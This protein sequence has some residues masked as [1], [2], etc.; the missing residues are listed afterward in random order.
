MAGRIRR[1]QVKRMDVSI[2]IEGLGKLNALIQALGPSNRRRLNAVAAKHLEARV[3]T[4]VARAA[5]GRHRTATALGARPTGHIVKGMRGIVGTADADGG[6]LVIPIPGI[7]RAYHDIELEP[8][9]ANRLTI[10]IDAVSYGHTAR[11]LA[12]RGWRFFQGMKGHEAEDILFG[13][14]GKGR[15]RVVKALFVLKTYVH[16]KRDPSLL[17][18][19]EECSGIVAKAMADEINRRIAA[20]RGDR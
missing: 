5:A 17:P 18:S 11:E 7:S 4:H 10:P 19:P 3:R 20:A 1:H 6:T 16:Q 15:N 12:A 8:V 13:Y 9:R 2:S 14:R